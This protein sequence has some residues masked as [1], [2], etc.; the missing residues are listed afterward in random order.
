MVEAADDKQIEVLASHP[1]VAEVAPVQQVGDDERVLH[2]TL[3]QG[4]PVVGFGVFY[5]SDQDGAICEDNYRLCIDSA[6]K[7][8]SLALDA[9]WLPE[10]HFTA[11]GAASPNPSVLC[12]ALAMLTERIA[13]RAG[14]VVLPLHHP[15]RV[16]EEWAMVDR[17]SNGRAGVSFAS[18]WVPDDFIFAPEQYSVRRQS[19]ADA[20]RIVQALWSGEAVMFKNGVGKSTSIKIRPTPERKSLPIWLTAA[21]SSETFALAGRLGANVLTALLQMSI[22][23]IEQNVRIYRDQRAEAGLDPQS[24][25]VTVMMHTYLSPDAETSE[26]E[27][28]PALRSY[29]RAQTALRLE[30]AKAVGRKIGDNPQISDRMLEFSVEKFV[31]ER[32]LIGSPSSVQHIVQRVIQAGAN[33]IACLVDFGIAA[34]KVLEGIGGIAEL[35]QA[36]YRALEKD[37]S[38][39]IAGIPGPRSVVRVDP[40]E[41][42]SKASPCPTKP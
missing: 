29:F 1:A 17:L 23:Q 2:V 30:A 19:M 31:R 42:S 40:H 14:S 11:V 32:C 37:L 15:V 38:R 4:F 3:S 33:E 41:S 12:A 20:V 26:R 39:M 25:N 21:S 8:D 34:D 9:V 5:F 7:A 35:K 36:P 22:E 13:L 27:A 10:R 18:G 6:V 16:A 24:G 28:R